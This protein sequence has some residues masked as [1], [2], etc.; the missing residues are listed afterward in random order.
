MSPSGQGRL[1]GLGRPC[2]CHNQSYPS[3]L[4]GAQQLTSVPELC[5]RVEG[6]PRSL[7][8]PQHLRLESTGAEALIS[9]SWTTPQQEVGDISVPPCSLGGSYR[10]PQMETQ[11]WAS[12]ATRERPGE[13]PLAGTRI[14][15]FAPAPNAQGMSSGRAFGLRSREGS[16]PLVRGTVKRVP[17]P[18]RLWEKKLL[19]LLLVPS[20]G[21]WNAFKY[22]P[23]PS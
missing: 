14:G 8:P 17:P 4:M 13:L 2:R 22:T 15:V 6:M 3:V 19:S 7:R 21:G 1:A 18:C 23:L 16:S 20:S 9:D 12:P 11:S 10:P 5:A